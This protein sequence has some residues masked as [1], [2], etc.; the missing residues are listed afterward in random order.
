MRQNYYSRAERRLCVNT[1]LLRK[2]K[3]LSCKSPAAANRIIAGALRFFHYSAI[4]P[5]CIGST[6]RYY[7]EVLYRRK[8]R[9]LPTGFIYAYKMVKDIRPEMT[10]VQRNP[11][12]GLF[13]SLVIIRPWSLLCYNIV[14]TIR[15][16]NIII[17]AIWANPTSLASL[18]SLVT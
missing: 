2:T 14:P 3:T 15:T 5:M 8:S 1:I 11:R 4:I 7:L 12:Q 9:Y 13:S 16:Y 18:N 17:I 6:L 10:C